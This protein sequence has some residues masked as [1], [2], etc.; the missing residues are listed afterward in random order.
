MRVLVAG[1]SP[2]R[3]NQPSA[4][5]DRHTTRSP[6][7]FAYDGLTEYIL[8]RTHTCVCVCY[9]CFLT[10]FLL[11]LFFFLAI[12]LCIK[13]I[14]GTESFSISKRSRVAL[15]TFAVSLFIRSVKVSRELG[16]DGSKYIFLTFFYCRDLFRDFT[17]GLKCQFKRVR[18]PV[19]S[20]RV[21]RHAQRFSQNNRIR[22]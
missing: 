20:Y 16:R 19:E 13:T 4:Q 12:P 7:R 5:A 14:T 11:L 3:G 18:L 6:Y 1:P 9:Y 10:R 21:V 2:R 15:D 22:C 8:P 17:L